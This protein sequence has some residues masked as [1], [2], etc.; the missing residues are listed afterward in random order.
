MQENSTQPGGLPKT[1]VCANNSGSWNWLDRAGDE[2]TMNGIESWVYAFRGRY[3]HASMLAPKDLEEN[4]LVILNLDYPLLAHYSSV[5]EKCGDARAR[6]VGL[7]EA[8]LDRVHP[9]RTQWSQVADQCD[10]VVAINEFGLDYL[11]GMTSSP[12]ALVGLPYPVDGMRELAI[13]KDER[14]RALLL[15]GWLLDR[16]TD[17]DAVKGLGLP[18]V[19]YERT[20]K[21]TFRRALQRRAA[22]RN[23]WVVRAREVYN[24]PGLEVRLQT[25]LA[26]YFRY[27]RKLFVWVNL[28][29][30]Y[31][32]ARY[33]LDAAALGIPIITTENT[34]QG[35]RLFPDLVVQ[36]P[37]DVKGA[38]ALARRLTEDADFYES[39]V[40]QA[41]AQLDWYRPEAT[42]QRLYEALNLTEYSA[43]AVAEAAQG[44]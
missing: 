20:F 13:P 16:S 27:V 3:K 2:K 24:D 33:V 31:T 11:S 22:D 40:V 17:Y 44:G 23:R 39:V 35:P 7:F 34:W 25:G 10:L 6:V 4:D 28:D 32:W 30:R 14:E 21:R 26:E 29:A 19:G 5:L 43:A 36:S 9:F 8:S 38:E 42:V 18:V 1:L 37:Y 12:V 41:S 15:C